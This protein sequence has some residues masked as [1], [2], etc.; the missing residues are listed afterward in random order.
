MISAQTPYVMKDK[1]V[2]AVARF[3]PTRVNELSC[4]TSTAGAGKHVPLPGKGRRAEFQTGTFRVGRF[5][6]WRWAMC[7]LSALG[8]TYANAS[9]DAIHCKPRFSY[10]RARNRRWSN[11]LVIRIQPDEES[12]SG[13][14]QVRVKWRVRWVNIV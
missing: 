7:V 10:S 8:Q 5:D 6:N 11:V 9:P 13:L 1:G 3:L 4:M 2:Q 12:R 14:V